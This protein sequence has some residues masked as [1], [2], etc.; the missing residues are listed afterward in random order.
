MDLTPEDTK[1]LD[2]VV[3]TYRFMMGS[4]LSAMNLKGR[5]WVETCN[6]M[7][8]VNRLSDKLNGIVKNEK[9]PN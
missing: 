6:H 2:E 1:L 3:R 8:A 5:A 9:T 4:A 7:A